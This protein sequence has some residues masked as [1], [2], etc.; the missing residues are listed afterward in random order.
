MTVSR[1]TMWCIPITI[2][3]CTLMLGCPTL[4]PASYEPT[5]QPGRHEREQQQMQHGAGGCTPNFST[6][7]C[8]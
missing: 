5:G 6:G 7:G 3:V 4:G 1:G 8:L 2:A